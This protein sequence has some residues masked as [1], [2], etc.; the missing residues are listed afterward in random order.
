MAVLTSDQL[1][2]LR[3]SIQREWSTAIDF[4]KATA[5]ATLQAIEDWYEGQR[6]VV[7]GLINTASAP[8]SFT[9]AEKKLIAKH[10]LKWKFDQG[11]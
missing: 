10:F 5:N 4:N 1:A 2:E 7:S 11:G 8:K 9:A 3:R 6:T